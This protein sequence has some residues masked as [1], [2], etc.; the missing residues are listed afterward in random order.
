MTDPLVAFNRQL[1]QAVLLAASEEG[2]ESTLP[3]AFTEHMLAYLTEAGEVVDAR[4]SAYESRGTAVSGLEVSEDEATL[5]V[6]LA[7]Y[8][9]TPGVEASAR[10]RWRRTS[11]ACCDTSTGPARASGAPS[12]S[13]PTR[14]T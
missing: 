3:A 9:A 8:R 5:H 1:Q 12:R 2:N 11:V 7:D 4:P 10:P 6:F 13:P 14:G